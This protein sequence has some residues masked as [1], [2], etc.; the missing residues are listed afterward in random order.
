MNDGKKELAFL[1]RIVKEAWKTC[2][3]AELNVRDKGAFDLVTDVDFA[4]EKFLT[5][6]IKE[7]FA[8]DVVVGEELNPLRELPMGRVWTVDPIDGTVNMAHG[9]P[10]FGVQCAFCIDGKPLAAVIYLPRFEE[11]YTALDGSGARLNGTPI[12]VSGRAAKNAMISVGDYSHKTLSH[13]MGQV[14]KVGSIYDSVSK[15]RHFGAAS[16][17]FAWFAAGKTDGFMMYTRNL[18]DLV[19]GWL[20]SVEAG[21]VV[22]S[23]NGGEYSLAE[24]G[25]VV[26]ASDD[27]AEVFERSA[28]QSKSVKSE[29]S[30]KGGERLYER[31]C[32][33][34]TC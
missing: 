13:A 10:L 11:Y 24:E 5:E 33:R 19:P 32:K 18:W 28:A 20:L 34:K 4:M 1:C 12:K 8:G 15:M 2:G 9:L 3:G 16:V 31:N 14:E 23:I 17:D 25:I 6:A 22:R 27:I 26:S 21:G 30:Q 29:K 7:N